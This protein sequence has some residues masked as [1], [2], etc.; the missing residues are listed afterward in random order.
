MHLTNFAVNK[1]SKA[2][3]SGAMLLCIVYIALNVQ[4]FDDAEGDGEGSKRGLTAVLQMLE[5][6][7]L[8]S[9][10]TCTTTAST[11]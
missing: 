7:S 1:K 8:I 2:T 3:S 9:H 10:M 11:R 6:A 5:Q 4:D